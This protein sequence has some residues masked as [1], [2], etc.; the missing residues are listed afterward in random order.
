M[1]SIASYSARQLKC[2]RNEWMRRNATV[3]AVVVAGVVVLGVV[4]SLILLTVDATRTPARRS[5][6]SKP[7]SWG[8]RP[9]V[10]TVLPVVHS[11]LIDS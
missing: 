3:V 9:S 8:R 4:V 1:A 5:G 2:R 10:E 11:R 7:Q 6:A